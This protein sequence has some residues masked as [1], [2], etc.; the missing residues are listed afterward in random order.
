VLETATLNEADLA[1]YCRKRALYP[2][3][4]KDWRVA[5]EQSND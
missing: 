3:Q 2:V 5:C 1:E 4:I